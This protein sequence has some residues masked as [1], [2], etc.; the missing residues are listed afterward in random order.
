MYQV[1]YYECILIRTQR[2]V[3]K[4]E[5]HKKQFESHF[6]LDEDKEDIL[7]F[8]CFSVGNDI[9]NEECISRLLYGVEEEMLS[10]LVHVALV[11]HANLLRDVA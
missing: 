1:P 9:T 3:E 7:T 10:P 11:P 2:H 8:L 5:R 6:L 4:Y